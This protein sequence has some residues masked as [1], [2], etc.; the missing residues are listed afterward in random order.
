MS[1]KLTIIVYQN[2]LLCCHVVGSKF[3]DISRIE[4]DIKPLLVWLKRFPNAS[5][6]LLV[7][8]IEEEVYVENSPMLFSWEQKLFAARQM[9][10]RF[11]KTEFC[12]YQFS[13]PNVLPW[14]SRAGFLLVSGFN[15][16]T[17]LTKLLSWLDAAEYPVLSIYSVNLLLPNLFKE[18]WFHKQLKNSSWRDKP[19]FLLIRTSNDNF[20]QILIV[21]GT[22]RATRQIQIRSHTVEGQMQQLLQEIKMLDK[23]VHTQKMVPYDETP[24]LY[25][26]GSNDA[27]AASAWNVFQSTSFG[28]AGSG[29]FIAIASIVHDANK[30][31]DVYEL[32]PILAFRHKK[33]N[34]HYFPKS[35]YE[36]IKFQNINYL[37]W[38]SL[39]VMIIFLISYFVHFGAKIVNFNEAMILLENQQ[40]RYQ[41]LIKKMES[42]LKLNI[43][44]DQLRS[45]VELVEYLSKTEEKQKSLPYLVDL[46]Q[47]LYSYPSIHLVE[48]LWAPQKSEEQSD[49]KLDLTQFS[50]TLNAQ[51]SGDKNTRL[52]QILDTMDKFLTDIT[53]KPTILS[54]E[55]VEKP[56]NIDSSRPITIQAKDTFAEAQ[57]YPFKLILRFK[58]PL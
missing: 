20:R 25:Y 56:I 42:Q 48:V 13:T 32:L 40:L 34:R 2:E 39:L 4:F 5:I 50:L 55:L 43:P 15:D 52:N 33:Q 51:I 7:D 18:V 46:S 29:A 36:A 14:Q 24:D 10:K 37:I 27:D 45:S 22:L 49:N 9:R 58:Q 47:V 19:H 38:S 26:L 31:I 12:Q 11:P 35:V 1:E 54:A 21:Q 44:V 6:N 41:S 28:A 23:F 16:D 30:N 3:H 57:S 8:L 17:L 53:K